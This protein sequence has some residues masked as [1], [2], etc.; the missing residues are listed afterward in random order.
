MKKF[1]TLYL[2]FLCLMLAS[3]QSAFAKKSS[4]A[5]IQSYLTLSGFEAMLG[6]VPSQM[7]AM[8]QQMQLTAKDPNA[9]QE[10]VN[11]LVS[12]W[13]E[14]QIKA[15]TSEYVKNNLSAD[16]LNELLVWLKTDLAR[17]IKLAELK[18]SEASF[19]QDFMQYMA[20]IQSAP[21]TEDRVKTIRN[22]MDSTGM[23]DYSMEV[24]M[25]IIKSMMKGM[26]VAEGATIAPEMLS[27]QLQQIKGMMK[28][29]LEQQLIYMSYYMYEELNND[30]INTYAQFYQK[31]LGKKEM[32]V[33]AG[34]MN[35][36]LGVWAEQSFKQISASIAAQAE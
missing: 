28:P 32:K 16:E 12:S 7:Q 35:T 22:F 21:P 9:A 17:K 26:Q 2:T 19:P 14:G 20:K 27:N 1:S 8:S 6:G 29:Q 36:S 11:V 23:V 33:M 5:D 31:A 18:S 30:D 24:V 3:M 34:A 10:V 25:G 13:D 4:D 15:I